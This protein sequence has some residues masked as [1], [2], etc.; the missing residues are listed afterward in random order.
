MQ[1]DGFNS[2]LSPVVYDD[3]VLSI[4]TQYNTYNVKGWG[5][6]S[7]RIGALFTKGLCQIFRF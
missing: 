7:V 3:I 6:I 4:N 2:A 5:F 1:S